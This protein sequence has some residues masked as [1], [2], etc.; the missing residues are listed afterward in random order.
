MERSI[1]A[2]DTVEEVEVQHVTMQFLYKDSGQFVFMNME[3]YEQFS[4]PAAVVGK[5][6]IFLKKILR[7]MWS[8]SK[9]GL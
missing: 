4:I 5:Q 1:R 2:E 9:E 6:E 3:S 7:S 8:S